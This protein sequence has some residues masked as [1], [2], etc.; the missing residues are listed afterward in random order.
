MSWTFEATWRGYANLW[1]T[2]TLKGGN[3]A[4]QADRFAD[5]II[6]AEDQYRAV[7]RATGVPWYFCGALHMRESSCNF[8]GVLHNGEHIIGTGR[9]TS[10]VPAGRGPFADWVSAAIDAIKLKDMHRVQVWSVARMLYQA[11]VFNGLG[12]V[13]KGINSPYVW[14]GTNHEQSGKYTSDHNFDPNVEDKQLGVAAVL[15]RLAEKR[16][17]IAAD[18]Y[19]SKPVEPLPM[20]DTDAEKSVA[21]FALV[22]QSLA[23]QMKLLNDNVV[24][25]LEAQGVKPADPVAPA[26]VPVTPPA[27]APATPSTT[28][29]LQQPGVGLGVLGG[30]ATLLLQA[31]GVVGPP[32]GADATT[33]GQVLPILAG[34]TALL[35]AT[36]TLGSVLNAV[37]SVVSLFAQ[38][39][40]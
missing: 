17:D 34:G 4:T 6:A 20:P 33:A 28:P 15:I 39:K 13:S 40:A 14:A 7:Q 16:P 2:A 8:E 12:Y 25:L 36:G 26:P 22:L 10:L 11:E 27:P 1:R 9:L 21:D 31:F 23:A 24:R 5:E 18:L 30:L 32:I 3:D 19:P 35:G 29:A 38:R 37:S